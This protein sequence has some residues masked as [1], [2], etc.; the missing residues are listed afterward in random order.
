MSNNNSTDEKILPSSMLSME[1]QIDI[2][3]AFAIFH[4]KQGKGATYK[5]I[6]SI[7]GASHANVS[8]T[9]K[10]WKNLSLL[11]EDNSVYTPSKSLIEFNKK[12]Q[13]GNE[14]EAW[15]MLRSTLN[16]QWFVLLI[17]S[18]FELR[19]KIRS[20]DLINSLGSASDASSS[21]KNILTSIKRILD[22]LEISKLIINDGQGSYTLNHES[23]EKKR[24][25]I[26]N[27]SKDIMQIKINDEI[28]GIEVDALKEFVLSNGKKI[29]TE[30]NRLE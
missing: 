7:V 10:F 25:L 18:K 17:K 4:S 2:L 29:D 20:E 6:A 21:N 3:K 27:D 16:E 5:E 23:S 15:E 14:D 11:E 26:V 28:Y 19:D 24:E 8:G 30:I 9:L 12:I 1:K 13:W 22:L